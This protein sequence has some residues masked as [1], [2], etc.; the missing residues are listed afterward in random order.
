MTQIHDDGSREVFRED[1]HRPHP[2][3]EAKAYQIKNIGKFLTRMTCSIVPVRVACLVVGG[4][5]AYRTEGTADIAAKKIIIK[6]IACAALIFAVSF[7]SLLNGF[8][9]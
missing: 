3:K 7:L 1:F 8:P 5:A 4:V 6:Y 2:G 9:Q